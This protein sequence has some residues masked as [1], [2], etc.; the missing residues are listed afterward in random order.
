[1]GCC[2]LRPA[3]LRGGCCSML[4]PITHLIHR[5]VRASAMTYD[6]CICGSG[7]LLLPLSPPQHTQHAAAAG[8]PPDPEVGARVRHDLCI[9]GKQPQ[10]RL[11][12]AR[13]Q[14]HQAGADGRRRD[15]RLHKAAANTGKVVARCL[16]VC[17]VGVCVEECVA[18]AAGKRLHKAAA[19][20]RE[21]VVRFLVCSDGDVDEC[22]RRLQGCV[23]ALLGFE[24]ALQLQLQPP[25][26]AERAAA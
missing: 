6:F 5:Y 2:T 16:C 15:E 17:G 10:H 23:L 25:P 12:R 11:W 8:H 13:Q 4:C 19:H 18:C 20:S 1:M 7:C 26:L 22:A 21:V 24:S 14:R 3:S 9:R